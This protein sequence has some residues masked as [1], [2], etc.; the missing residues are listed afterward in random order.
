MHEVLLRRVQSFNDSPFS[1]CSLRARWVRVV[2][3]PALFP[4]CWATDCLIFPRLTQG[5][6]EPLKREESNEACSTF[7]FELVVPL[8]TTPD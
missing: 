3:A 2:L 6:H 7:D 4:D 5:A 8:K 1:A